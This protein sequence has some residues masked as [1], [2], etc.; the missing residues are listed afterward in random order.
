MA[1]KWKKLS[2]WNTNYE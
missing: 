1:E 2:I